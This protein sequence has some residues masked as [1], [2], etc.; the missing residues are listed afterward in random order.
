MIKVGQFFLTMFFIVTILFFLL[1]LLPGGPFD[2]EI[3]LTPEMKSHVEEKYKLGSP[4]YIQ[5][6]NYLNQL[7]HGDLGESYKFEDRKVTEILKETLPVTLSL[8]LCALFVSYLLGIGLGILS[9]GTRNSFVNSF[10]ELLANAGSS[11]P[12]FLAGPILIFLF[13]FY[14]DWLPPAL[15]ESPRYYILPLVA[16]SLRPTSLIIKL[17]RSSGLENIKAEYVQTARA[18]G[19]KDFAVLYKHVLKNS[20]IP[21]LSISG[22][23][24]AQILSGS[25]LVEQ[26]FAIPGVASH[27]VESVIDRDYSLLI[28]LTLVYAT[29]LI[30]TNMVMDE[31]ATLVDPRLSGGQDI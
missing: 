27:F 10:I 5:Y 2:G 12:T 21:L 20:L 9:I 3:A 31:V 23:L 29:I 1:R 16:L 8:G 19:V 17:I 28:G 13:S 30:I 26:I 24:F 25:F 14:L 11:I 18:K 4:L 15:W 7:L 22:S 6:F